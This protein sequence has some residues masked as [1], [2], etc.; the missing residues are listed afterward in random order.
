MF[1]FLL[2]RRKKLQRNKLIKFTLRSMYY[3]GGKYIFCAWNYHYV[4][5][6]FFFFYVA[7]S[8]VW[9]YWWYVYP[10]HRGK[11]FI[12]KILLTFTPFINNYKPNLQLQ[13]YTYSYH[14]RAVVQGFFKRPDTRTQTNAIW[15]PTYTALPLPL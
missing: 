14:L 8:Y 12:V 3:I 4:T 10:K 6:F 15:Y 1:L 11:A 7:Y 5:F 13:W 9:V 2:S